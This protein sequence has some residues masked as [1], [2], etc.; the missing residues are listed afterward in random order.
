[1]RRLKTP[2]KPIII[3]GAGPVGCVAALHLAQSGLDVILL[4][5][6]AELPTTL[7]AST[8]HPPTVDML[9]D[10]GIAKPL[11]AR[12]LLART[13][14]YR[15]RRNGDIAEFDYA[16][17]EGETRHPFR[18]QVEQWRLT[19]MIWS[20]LQAEHPN[21]ECRFE[22]IVRGVHQTTDGVEVLVSTPEG[23]SLIEGSFLIAADGADSTVRRAVGIPFEGFTYPERFVVASTA[24]PLEDKFERLCY[25]NYIAD[26]EEWLVLLRAPTLWR[27][28]IPAAA[29]IG[30]EVL[31]SS[32]E[33]LQERLHHM[34]PNDRD[35]EIAH[36]NVY[37]VHQR[38]ATH[39][40]RNRVFLAGDAAHI[41]NPLGG[42][43]MNGGIHDAVSLSEKIARYL[44]DSSQSDLLDLYERQRR[45]VCM[46]F[47]Q[48]Q[49]QQ[50]KRYLEESDP[51][52]HVKQQALRMRTAADPLLA[53]RH[54]LKTSMIQSLRDAAAIP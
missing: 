17:L 26:P 47:I 44:Q 36:R 23:E 37:R 34:A 38:V 19:Q 11:I 8:F 24:F 45:T 32:S 35:Y 1:M 20:H 50:N 48:E 14:Q 25:V 28:L 31:Q 51:E 40:R 46:R 39:Y 52:I 54:M 33:W 27:I 41:N 13:Y 15:D 43:G 21:V 16:Y 29:D 53:H 22:R 4:E 7:R 9:A 6:L 30:D 10:L 2:L 5:R 42:M 12:G 18:L 3:A 49:T